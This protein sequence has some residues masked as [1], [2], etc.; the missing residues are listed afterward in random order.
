[1]PIE[2]TPFPFA[3]F[4]NNLDADGLRGAWLLSGLVEEVICDDAGN[5]QD[6]LQHLDEAAGNG[7]WVAVAAAYELGHAIEARLRPLLPAGSGPL[8]QAWIFERGEWLDSSA[9]E[10]WLKAQA[11]DA[12]GGVAA[13]QADIA[14][15]AYLENIERIR[16][17]IADGDCYQVNYTFPFSG[18]A[19][20]APAALYQALRAAQPVR[21][22]AFIHHAGGSVLSRSPELFLE[23]RGTTLSSLPMKGTAA[24]DADPATLRSSEKDRAENVMIVDLIRND[25]G[26]LAPAGGVRV[27]ELFH[28]EPYPTVWQMISRVVA[29]P[30][31]AG[32]PEIF[33]ALFP[34]GSITGAPKIRAMEIIREL[35]PSP[36]G[37]YCGA[38]GFIRPGG[39]FR[40]SVPIRTLLVDADGEAKLNVGSGVVYDSS[41][42]GEWAECHLKARFLTA[43]PTPLRLIE[44][45]RYAPAGAA[46]EAFPFLAEHLERL[47]ASARWFGFPF[48]ADA[49][50]DTLAAIGG[51]TPLRVRVTL[52][53]GGDFSLETAPLSTG[54][55]A[56]APTVVLSPH[57]VRSNDPLL[58]HKTTAR[59]RYDQEL[60][61][62]M[63]EGHFD[64]LFL[65]ERDE[66]TEGARSNLFVQK[67]GEL[68]TPPQDA[69]LLNGVLRRRLLRE[70]QAREA[71]LTVADLDQAEAL[72]VGNGLR[73]LLRVHLAP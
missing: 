17:Y 1:M 26:R 37:I 29:E 68:L 55:P 40:L 33:R 7:A 20:G 67:D 63:A 53:Q 70:G 14:E 3:F 49:F 31:S 38:L 25:M 64:A 57:R 72:F 8:L 60:A 9:S 66:L 6:C 11:G 32:L 35:E 45:L 16:R 44:T 43:L 71:T 59:Q 39:D 34:C 19:Y 69:G 12:P 41:P 54:A 58:R 23:R 51:D 61:R 21:Y 62:V 18:Q 52:G 65:N 28:V 15:T 36:R 30:V 5:W 56:D 10:A 46:A 24:R 50:R 2:S 48:D 22:G 42:A 73:G 47:S 27:D 4:D 13:L